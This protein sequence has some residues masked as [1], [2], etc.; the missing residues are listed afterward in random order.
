MNPL[1]ES[2][3]SGQLPKF[4]AFH[5]EHIIPA[6]EKVLADNLE[7][8]DKLVMQTTQPT[9]QNFIEPLEALD[10]QLQRIW[11]P[12]G[13]LDAVKN[14]DEWHAAYNACLEKLTDYST[15]LGQHA[16]LF[17]QYQAL[18]ESAEYADYSL[19]QKKVIENNLRGFRLS[20]IDL[21]PEQQAQYKTISQELSQLTSQF[22]NHVLKSTQAWS[23]LI[24][25]ET[26][27][28]GLPDSAKGLL[29]QLAKQKDL[30]GWRV[31]L[32]F[33]S[34]IAVMTH[35]NNRALREAVYKAYATRASD[36]A[37]DTSFD[38]SE[39][40][41]KILKL[42][43]QKAHL[44]GF[45]N[46]AEYSLATKMADSTEQVIGFLED[47]ALK[48]KPQA[49]AEYDH[50]K[51]FAK[52]ELGI[53]DLQPWDVTFA[54]EKLKD[55]TLSLSQ[56]IL[57]PYF[58]LTKVLQGLFAITQQVFGVQIIEK[59]G[60]DVWHNEVRYFELFEAGSSHAFGG[61]Y[62]DLY[63]RENKRGGAWMDSAIGRWKHPV[64]ALQNPVAYLV[65]NFTPPVG[66]KPACLTHDEVTTLFHEFGHGIHHLMTKMEHLDVSGISGVPWDAVELPSQ[67]MEN[68]CWEQEGLDL[69]T[70]HIETG[71]TLPADLLAALKK[72]RGFQS[73]MMMLRQLEFSLFDFKLHTQY[74]TDSTIDV[75]VFAQQIRDQVAVVQLPKYHRFPH[76][77]SHIFAGGYAAG[78]F[79]Y[80]WAEVLSADA[81]SLFEETGIL[82]PETGAKF[83]NTILA[84]GGS[85]HPME[86][87]KAFRGREPS[88]EA[89]LRHSGI[90]A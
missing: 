81:F 71:E 27:L 82:N 32:D 41:Q 74:Q 24:E 44:L 3:G 43:V 30:N 83:K 11:G 28:E 77:F 16:G 49:Q 80:K 64:G 42:R 17:K 51:N 45:K 39:L 84:S 7:Q 62:L 78:Y 47:L 90:Q 52:T 75:L 86:L 12:V 65:C 37:D 40:I 68:F 56:E 48:S 20:G 14:T 89:L 25:N 57:K 26:D 88:I 10:N 33:P 19:A 85:V 76:S 36:Q 46:Y 23:K 73:A 87:F 69:M 66:D 4:S 8:I 5:V 58:P 63:A 31:T 21:P 13:H 38:N 54:S 70:Q 53:A 15:R 6:V 29:A 34:Y 9:W 50:L 79:S 1:Y 59:Q 72:S 22:S 55:K 60:V 67:F 35:A 18:A 61:F 2:G